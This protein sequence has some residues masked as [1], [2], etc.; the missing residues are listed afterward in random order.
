MMKL[1]IS[2]AVAVSCHA[3]FFWHIANSIGVG[4]VNR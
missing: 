2:N 3:G 4:V 1:T